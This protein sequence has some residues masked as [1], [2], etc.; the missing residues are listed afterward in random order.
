VRRC[1]EKRTG[2]EAHLAPFQNH[3]DILVR[4]AESGKGGHVL[5]EKDQLAASAGRCRM[6]F[7]DGF[8]RYPRS[9]ENTAF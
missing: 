3:T 4:T 9:E 1:C 7:L 5:D 2:T 8:E 6:L